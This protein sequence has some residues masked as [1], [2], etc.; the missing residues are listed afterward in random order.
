VALGRGTRIGPYE[1]ISRIGMGGMGEVYCATDTNL[2]R[3]V[4]IKVLASRV[5]ASPAR[6]ARFDLEA[7]ALAAL[8]HPNIAAIYGLERSGATTALVM[9]LVEGPTLADL[10]DLRRGSSGPIGLPLEE[11]LPIAR[12]IAEAVRA[13]HDHGIIHRDLKPANIKVRPDGTVKVL[14][15]GLAKVL[16]PPDAEPEASPGTGRGATTVTSPA[17]LTHTGVILGTAAYMS[18]EQ[19]SGRIVDVR[20]DIWAFGCVLY[21]ML[22]GRRAFDGASVPETLANVL[23]GTPDWS[24][25]PAEVSP[26]IGVLLRR[27]LAPDPRQR[28][29]H[30]S[31][32]SLVLEEERALSGGA[33]AAVSSGRPVGTPILAALL[34]GVLTAGTLAWL[35]PDRPPVPVVR[36]IIDEGTFMSGTDRNFA[37]TPD[38]SRL[39]YVSSRAN[40]ILVR[41]IDA[42]EAVPILTTP[43]YVT[44]V[45]PSPDGQWIAYIDNRFTLRRI[46]VTGGPPST[47]VLMDGPSRGAAWGPDDTIVFATGASGT[48]L[49][50][51]PARGGAVTVLTRPDHER[52]EADH[53]QPAWL[54]GGR[55]LLFTILATVG[56][57][58]AAKVAVLDIETGTWRTAIEG[59]FSA[60]YVETGHILYGASGALWAVRFDLSRLE[61]RGVPVRV[62]AEVN[63]IGIGAVASFDVSDNGSLLY[64]RGAPSAG[65]DHLPVWVDR[66]GRETPL[67]ARPDSYQH[68]RLSPDGTRLAIAADQDLYVWDLARPSLSASRLTL[69][70]GIDWF[71][72]W[73][74]DG[75]RIV[76]GSWRG[77]GFSNLYVQELD[78]GAAERLTD[79]ADMQA[80]TAISPDGATLV[81]QSFPRG[82]HTLRLPGAR[83][84]ATLVDTPLEERNGDLSPDGR[85]LAYEGEDA[86]SP[87]QLDIYVR[88]FPDVD[89]G[90]WRVTKDG[91]TF[92]LWA[93]RGQELFYQ[94]PDGT[95]VAVPIETT[96]AAWRA[97]IARELFRGPYLFRDGSLGRQYD[98]TLDGRRFLMLKKIDASHINPHFVLVQNWVS[99]LRRAL[100]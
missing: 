83:Q 20:A 67:E 45:F 94:K 49:Q 79:S 93:K 13:A 15:F 47:V 26:A 7:R 73:T 72:V 12:Q 68:P 86:S 18:P 60:R 1:V 51:V 71:P 99:E 24:R 44:G 56:G 53:V 33:T 23:R 95:L 35:L 31:T 10:I 5:D 22:T 87:G 34:G 46:G 4:A 89:S 39:V 36:T 8:N 28:V 30:I 37:L 78:S 85:W 81:F 41:P 9:E 27:C 84:P 11:A 54:P 42:L 90:V 52:G 61:A 97:G 25:L 66:D 17:M 58:D 77:G 75:R 64:S 92:P 74:P 98:V 2:A 91:G 14:D 59:G 76:F 29:A 82:I 16:A 100:P 6:L 38:G 57:L 3:Q 19:A 55:R 63:A 62:H 40:Q 48:G 50:Q 88:P 80:P 32:V 69:T 21:E 96:G 65:G 43:S 70:P